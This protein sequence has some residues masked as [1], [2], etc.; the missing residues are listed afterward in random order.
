[1]DG[2]GAGMC[3]WHTRRQPEQCDF[4]AP[5]NMERLSIDRAAGTSGAFHNEGWAAMR[6]TRERARD[7]EEERNARVDRL[8]EECRTK[9]ENERAHTPEYRAIA[10]R[11]SDQPGKKR[12]DGAGNHIS[13]ILVRAG[14]VPAP[15]RSYPQKESGHGHDNSDTAT[16][17]RRRHKR[18][19]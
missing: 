7:N 17:R 9:S 18:S 11:L 16:T 13:T 19:S 8:V 1:M 2:I 6:S 3:G 10:S 4:L 15:L 14:R 12:V 5:V